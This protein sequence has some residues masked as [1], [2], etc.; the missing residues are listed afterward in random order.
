MTEERKET[1]GIRKLENEL[2]TLKREREES[3][4][5]EKS[6]KSEKEVIGEEEEDREVIEDKDGKDADGETGFYFLLYP[7]YAV[8]L[9]Q[10]F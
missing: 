2:K 6:E 10:L 7:R 3:K 5:S 4:E 8:E 1:T 9:L